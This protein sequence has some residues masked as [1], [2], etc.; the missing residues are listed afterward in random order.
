MDEVGS[1]CGRCGA[2]DGA[3]YK[4]AHVSIDADEVVWLCPPCF[5][6]VLDR[7]H[8][9]VKEN[10]GVLQSA[11]ANQT[12]EKLNPELPVWMLACGMIVAFAGIVVAAWLLFR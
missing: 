4:W 1:G 5:Q 11:L 2:T 10:A 7:Q 3:L 12:A 8:L 9:A 6:Y